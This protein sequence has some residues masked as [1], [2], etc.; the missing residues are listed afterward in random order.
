MVRLGLQMKIST[1]LFSFATTFTGE[2][3][4]SEREVLPQPVVAGDVSD[5]LSTNS[6]RV[7]GAADATPGVVQNLSFSTP[8]F[9]PN[10]DGIHDHLRI[11]YTLFR[12]PELVPVELEIYALDGRRLTRIDAGLQGSGPR[13]IEWDG[14]DERGELLPPGIY[15]LGIAPNA[16]FA[17]SA[18]IR[19]LGIAY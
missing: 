16:E 15:L 8:V 6:L 9:T 12:L 11:R 7:L 1:A 17:T 3:L 2:V 10:G 18:Q 5:A 4:D 19:P 13:E 14:R